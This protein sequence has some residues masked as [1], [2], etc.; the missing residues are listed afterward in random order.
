MHC[1]YVE[2][3]WEN[4]LFSTHLSHI[5][6]KFISMWY[7]FITILFLYLSCCCVDAVSAAVIVTLF[8]RRHQ[9]NELSAYSDNSTFVCLKCAEG[10]DTCKDASPCVAALNWPMR[11]SILVLACAVIGFLP[12]AAWFTFRYQ[13]VK[14]SDI[15]YPLNWC[16]P[17]HTSRFMLGRW[18]QINREISGKKWLILIGSDSLLKCPKVSRNHF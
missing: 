13:Q 12:P 10:C 11:T 5:I 8:H 7:I 1:E 3:E 15:F 17:T 4:C 6:N 18:F 2:H 14:V 16:M 9:Q